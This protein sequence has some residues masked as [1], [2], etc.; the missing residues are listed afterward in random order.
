M[1][2]SRFGRVHASMNVLIFCALIVSDP[3]PGVMRSLFVFEY[4]RITL[5]AQGVRTMR[6]LRTRLECTPES[7]ED[8]PDAHNH[9]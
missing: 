3:V 1:D 6:Q 7:T 2:K 9:T 4:Y 8:K 5:R